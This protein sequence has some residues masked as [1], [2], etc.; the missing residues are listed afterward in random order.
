MKYQ[1]LIDKA[2][3]CG[4]DENWNECIEYYEQAL[5]TFPKEATITDALDLAFAYVESGNSYKGL[6]IIEDLIFLDAQHPLPHYYLGLYHIKLDNKEEGLI[7]FL[8]A[9]E[10]GYN[11]PNVLFNIGLIYDDKGDYDNAI[12]YYEKTLELEP[13][14]FYANLNLGA[15]YQ[16]K[17]ELQKSLDIALNNLKVN[18]DMHL[19]N[20]NV[21]VIY[22]LLGDFKTA[23]K[24][25]LEELTKDDFC[26]DTYYNLG[27]IYKDKGNL[28]EAKKYYLLGLKYNTN[29][30]RIWYNLGCVHSLASDF[31]NAYDCLYASYLINNKVVE[32]IKEDDE[33]KGF[34]NTDYYQKLIKNK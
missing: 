20:Y 4:A 11:S 14:D 5:R 7:E 32:Y 12:I 28:E 3:D 18:P 10:N 15:I 13:N 2:I 34:I 22:G 26:K 24:Y 19:I 21:G 8:K 33:L 30:S 16:E 23:A 17:G 27:I 31:E 25:Y 6:E 29:D 9:Y 1:D